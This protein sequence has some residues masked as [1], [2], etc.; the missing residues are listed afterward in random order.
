MAKR[1][2][3]TMTPTA[4][5]P[6]VEKITVKRTLF[7]LDTFKRE[8]KETKVDPP[9]SVTTEAELLEAIGGDM[10]RLIPIYNT[11]AKRQA[12]NDAKRAMGGDGLISPKVISGLL[13]GFAVNF[14]LS[15]SGE[16]EA[17]LKVARAEQKEKIY[18]YVRDNPPIHTALKTIAAGMAAAATEDEDEDETDG[19]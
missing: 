18:Q 11:G 9:K 2:T 12:I 8:S 6:T 16:D 13:S 19:E 1:K 7:N 5:A 15:Y 14:P 10:S 3:K 17:K 4:N